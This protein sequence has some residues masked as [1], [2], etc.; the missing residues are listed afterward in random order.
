MKSSRHYKRRSN[1]PD[2]L[3]VDEFSECP[4]KRRFVDR[5]EPQV[6]ALLMALQ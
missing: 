5:H 3:N 6:H 4:L 1:I 2:G